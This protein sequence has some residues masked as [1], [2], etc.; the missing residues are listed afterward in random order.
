[1]SQ[2]EE[3]RNPVLAMLEGSPHT[4]S[5]AD[6]L[7]SILREVF[8]TTVN[9]LKVYARTEFKDVDELQ[10]YVFDNLFRFQTDYNEVQQRALA[11]KFSTF[12]WESFRKE[13]DTRRQGTHIVHRKRYSN[14]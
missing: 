4:S 7:F 1:M 12:V 2:G 5:S 8:V 6:A 3:Q 10:A 11:M 13:N 14:M 9:D